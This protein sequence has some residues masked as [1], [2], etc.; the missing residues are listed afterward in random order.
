MKID[1]RLQDGA[2]LLLGLKGSLDRD[3]AR[4]LTRFLLGRNTRAVS[5]LELD[6]GAVDFIGLSAIAALREFCTSLSRRGGAMVISN[7]SPSVASALSTTM[8]A[9]CWN[10]QN[11]DQKRE[12]KDPDG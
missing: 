5:R 3:G 11:P 12:N 8:K 2:V 6:L 1:I 10:L 9:P 4:K 7:P